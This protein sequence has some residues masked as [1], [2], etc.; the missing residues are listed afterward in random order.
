MI[1]AKVY[2]VSFFL[3][4]SRR[5]LTYFHTTGGGQRYKVQCIAART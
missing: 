1:I 4:I 3:S 2:A 5:V